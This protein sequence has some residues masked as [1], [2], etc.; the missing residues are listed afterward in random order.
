[1]GL[2]SA[3]KGLLIETAQTLKGH[4]RRRF[5]V[6]VVDLVPAIYHTGVRLSQA[7]MATIEAQMR[8]CSS[9]LRVKDL[10][11]RHSL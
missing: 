8:L 10:V 1:M 9:G 7:A 6:Q 2:S 5:I 4:A 11:T 3:L